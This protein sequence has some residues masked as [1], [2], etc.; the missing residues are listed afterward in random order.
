MASRPEDKTP[1]HGVQYSIT[2]SCLRP[3]H[4]LVAWQPIPLTILPHEGWMKAKSTWDW[5]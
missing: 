5:E 1:A 3:E 2:F 4:I